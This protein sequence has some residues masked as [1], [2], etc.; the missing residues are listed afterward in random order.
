[1]PKLRDFVVLDFSGGLITN[2]SDYVLSRKGGVKDIQ[3]FDIDYEGRL[4]RRRGF[5]Q[6]G[7]T[8]SGT[9]IHGITI[10]QVASGSLSPFFAIF[11]EGSNANAYRLFTT[12]LEAG[13][14]PG[15]SSA[16]V[17]DNTVFASSGTF[18][19]NGD[20]VTYT[21]KPSATAFTT[22]GSTI[23]VSHLAGT[24]VNQWSTAIATGVDSRAGIYTSALG[25][26]IF[27]GG[28]GQA[29]TTADFQTFT[30]RTTNG[31]N[32]FAVTYRDRVYAAGDGGSGSNADSIRVCFSNAGDAT[33]WTA[34]D[35]FDVE[36]SRREPITGLRVI[37]DRLAVFKTNSTLSYNEVQLK[38]RLSSVGAYNNEVIQ[39]IEGL[40]Y[41][42]CPAGVFVTNGLTA[43]KISEPVS[44][45]LKVF[46]PQYDSQY[47]RVVNNCF[48]GVWNKKYLL[49]L[50][51]IF[52]PGND[53]RLET[54]RGVVLVYDTIKKNWTKY[55]DIV[56]GSTNVLRG[57]LSA[58]SFLG[59]NRSVGGS[60]TPFLQ[61][62]EAL[63]GYGAG[64]SVL[65]RFFE[66]SYQ[67]TDSG[68]NQRGDSIAPDNIAN[69]AGSA[70]SCR[71]ETPF[72]DLNAVGWWKRAGYLR[73]LVGQGDFHISYRWDKGNSYTDWISLGNFT[74][75]NERKKLNDQEGFRISLKITSN[76]ADILSE[77][78]GFVVE[79]IDAVSQKHYYAPR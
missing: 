24:V 9:V 23:R 29:V 28:R 67:G 17:V 14:T 5:Y 60:I 36:D 32:M 45:V 26:I 69:S 21:A 34:A 22:T 43:R 3:N 4:R 57:F 75:S 78:N 6:F 15:D 76:Q 63:F 74:T 53:N 48:A 65:Y 10:A 64:D 25:G 59:G 66:N 42:F 44:E 61:G 31:A 47:Q 58:P 49:Y 70:V 40:T 46:R 71:I 8:V 73:A 52:Y 30:N 1:M 77:F 35:N 38:Q 20:L 13:L 16:S 72:Y 56:N 37:N 79:E 33:M 51:N 27:V 2:R 41:T 19:V 55:R 62:I 7:T 11:T 50:G 12:S 18:E 39:E 68:N 54:Q